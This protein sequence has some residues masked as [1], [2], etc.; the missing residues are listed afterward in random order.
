MANRNRSTTQISKLF[1]LIFINISLAI[2]IA[3][4]CTIFIIR[5]DNIRY[6]NSNAYNGYILQSSERY[7]VPPLLI[8]AIIWQESHFNPW[9]RNHRTGA[10]GLMQLMTNNAGAVA[11]WVQQ[12][13]LEAKPIL[14]IIQDPPINIEIGTWY[15][16]RAVTYWETQFTNPQTIYCLALAEYNAGRSNAHRW[17][18]QNKADDFDLSKVTFKETKH[19]IKQIMAKWKD[20]EHEAH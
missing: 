2:L 7:G 8:K 14:P 1:N 16:A 3:L 18:P 5:R 13:K 12:H 15:F 19:Y 11:E 9:A 4:V 20:Y 6:V 17:K 10:L